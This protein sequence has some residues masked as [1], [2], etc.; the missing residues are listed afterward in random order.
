MEHLLMVICN[1]YFLL[2]KWELR[3][4]EKEWKMQFKSVKCD[5]MGRYTRAQYAQSMAVF[6]GVI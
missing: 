5:V 2:R 4:W 6:W 3:K 1:F